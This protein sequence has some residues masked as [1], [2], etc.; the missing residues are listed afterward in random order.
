MAIISLFVVAYFARDLLLPILLGFLLAL[1][2]SPLNRSL[3]RVGLPAGFSATILIIL[4]AIAVL[5]TVF[6]AGETARSWSNDAPSIARELQQKL[7]GVSETIDAVQEASDEVEEMTGAPEKGPEEVVVQQPGLLNTAVTVA[8]STVT[9]IA[10]ALILALFLLASGDLFYVKLVQAFPTMRGKKRALATVYGIERRVSAYL[11]TITLINAG[12][13]VCVAGALWL[14]GLEYAYVWGIAAFLL[15]FLP[16]LGAIIG[17]AMVAVHAIIYFDTLSYAILA[18]IAYQILTSVEAQFITPY[19]VGKRMELN[20]VAVF[21]TVVLWGWLWGIAGT[22][23]AVPFL[24]VFKVICENFDNLKV[25][26]N[27]LGTED[28]P[29]KNTEG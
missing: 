7:R 22:L 18:P 11:L 12:L 5:A 6:F 17:V 3:Q 26:G 4:S 2:L 19:L 27:F 1:T 28:E 20:V 16:I 8:A 24:L 29:D 13:G 10:V 21:L 14:L 9:S 25:I 15:N 23:V